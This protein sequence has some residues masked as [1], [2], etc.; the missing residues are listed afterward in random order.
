MPE[1]LSRA[2][3]GLQVAAR[4]RLFFWKGRWAMDEA[5]TGSTKFRPV[6][7]GAAA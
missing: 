1:R 6:C 5:G 3:V 4:A 2:R 7:G